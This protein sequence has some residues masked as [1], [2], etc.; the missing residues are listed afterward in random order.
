[1]VAGEAWLAACCKG[2][3]GRE[4]NQRREGRG[5]ESLR[6]VREKWG[7][8]REGG[9]HFSLFLSLLVEVPKG[10]SCSLDFVHIYL[11]F[12]YLVACKMKGS[13]PSASHRPHYYFPP[14]YLLTCV[15]GTH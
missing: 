12:I 3:G 2:G 11:P 1:M 5:E 13:A 14:R 7:K 15:G 8:L 4:G 10:G 6:A 9:R